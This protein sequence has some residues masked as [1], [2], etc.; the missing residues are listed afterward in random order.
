MSEIPHGS[1]FPEPE[2][3][4]INTDQSQGGTPSDEPSRAQ[5]LE[6]MQAEIELQRRGAEIGAEGNLEVPH[7]VILDTWAEMHLE[8]QEKKASNSLEP[9]TNKDETCLVTEAKDFTPEE[10]M[11]EIAR[12]DN[13]PLKDLYVF[14]I[15][16]DRNDKVL[17]IMVRLSTDQALDK[18][19]KPVYYYFRAKSSRFINGR[20]SKMGRSAI[21][22]FEEDEQVKV[23]IARNRAAEEL[24]TEAEKKAAQQERSEHPLDYSQPRDMIAEFDGFEW[25]IRD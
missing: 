17:A 22:R 6:W 24:G 12:I 10:I 25:Q 5:K 14:G 23:N 21:T 13:I 20:L 18:A 16:L 15:T 19:G 3:E 8:K 1:D 11:Y 4:I 2:S 9:R 7:D